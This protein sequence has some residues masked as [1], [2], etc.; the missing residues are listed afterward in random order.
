[1]QALNYFD[2]FI[3]LVCYALFQAQTFCQTP[4]HILE[5]EMMVNLFS[6]VD[7]YSRILTTASHLLKKGTDHAAADSVGERDMLDW[8]LIGDMHPLRFQI[9]V[10]CNFAQQWPAR[11]AGI[12]VPSDITETLTVKEF[13]SSLST[14]KEFLSTLRSEQFVGRE[15]V[16]VKFAIGD[17]T[18]QP[19]LPAGQWLIVFATTNIYF[20]L[21][22]TYA[23]LRAKGVRIGKADLF[24]SGL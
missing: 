24:A 18:M 12:T 15:D 7:L 3:I 20:H 5:I 11:V 21:S 1:L 10:V 6:F 4:I 13:Q 14:A 23:I 22:M 17:G 2:W 8:R 19:T 16:P 9:M